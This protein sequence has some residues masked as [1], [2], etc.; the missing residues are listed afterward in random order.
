MLPPSSVTRNPSK[1]KRS[2]SCA[3][4]WIIGRSDT[5]TL[6]ASRYRL[7]GKRGA[8]G[9]GRSQRPEDS[10]L[11]RLRRT[12]EGGVIGYQSKGKIIKLEGE[13]QSLAC[14]LAKAFGLGNLGR[15]RW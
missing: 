10:R 11:P 12:E 4:L 2:A 6:R 8:G 3:E 7:F 13:E 5:T 14:L 1:Q 15:V 9:K